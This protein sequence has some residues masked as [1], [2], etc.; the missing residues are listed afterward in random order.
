MKIETRSRTLYTIDIYHLGYHNPSPYGLPRRDYH[1]SNTFFKLQYDRRNIYE[2][3][4]SLNQGISH[5]AELNM[6]RKTPVFSI[7]M[8]QE[9]HD[10]F[11]TLAEELGMS[12]REFM[13]VAL[14]KQKINYKRA[15][16][17][18]YN[19][20]YNIGH[21]AVYEKGKQDWGVQFPCKICD[22]LAYIQ[23]NS[24]CHRAVIEFLRE[25]VWVHEECNEQ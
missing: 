25:R 7:R 9:F 8:P 10:E 4:Q 13:A 2:K 5:Q 18:G 6:K 14:K 3:K 16:N 12:R 23:P 19:K 22:E 17:Q 1:I 20:G 21:K 15:H 11:Q 24:D